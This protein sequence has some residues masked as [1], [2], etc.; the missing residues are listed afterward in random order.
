M[1]SGWTSAIHSSR[2]GAVSRGAR[3]RRWNI[4]SFQR[5]Q[6]SASDSHV[7]MP[8]WLVIERGAL[9]GF[10]QRVERGVVLGHVH[11]DADDAARPRMLAVDV[12]PHDDPAHAAVLA[13]D[14]QLDLGRPSPLPK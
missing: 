14:A 5:P 3:P 8:A 13:Q 10:A 9:A 1:S 12:R 11:G 6:P 7:P 2:L 4:C